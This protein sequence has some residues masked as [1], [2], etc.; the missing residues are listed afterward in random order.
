[1]NVARYWARADVVAVDPRGREQDRSVYRGS[2]LS[3]ADA[4]RQAEAAAA[5]IAQ[6]I[7]DGGEADWYDYQ[8]RPRPE[9]IE[10]E[11]FSPEGVRA[12]AITT[13]R[14][15][16]PVLNTAWLVI[17]DV[18]LPVTPKPPGAIARLL[19]KKALPPPE[20]A[21]LATVRAWCRMS[22]ARSARLYRTAGGLRYI[23]PNMPLDPAS[24]DAQGLMAHLG[25]DP[26]YAKLCTHQRSYRARLAPKPWR[27]AGPANIALY[28]KATA[29]DGPRSPRVDEYI[30]AREAH[31]VC[32]LIERLGPDPLDDL[33]Q[34]LI[35]VHDER[36]KAGSGLPL[37]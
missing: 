11:W 36:C 30:K 32:T 13:N 2:D 15:G 35:G 10:R 19:G 31:A 33:E 18:D 22:T 23:L 6:R 4:K 16:I 27:L 24:D 1:M 28:N 14:H 3:E 7:R 5:E 8:R 17:V 37:A 25:A 26:R 20:D 21:P 9:P 29:E 34:Q 12:A